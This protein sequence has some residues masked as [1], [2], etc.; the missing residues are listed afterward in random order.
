MY[1]I[2]AALPNLSNTIRILIFASKYGKGLPEQP[3]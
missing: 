1:M 3:F 2:I